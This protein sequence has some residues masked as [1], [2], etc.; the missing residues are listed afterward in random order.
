MI[1][2]EKQCCLVDQTGKPNSNKSRP[3]HLSTTLFLQQNVL[4]VWLE[5]LHWMSIFDLWMQMCSKAAWAQIFNMRTCVSRV[6]NMIDYIFSL[7]L[8]LSNGKQLSL[9]QETRPC[10]NGFPLGWCDH[11]SLLEREP[12][13]W[14]GKHIGIYMPRTNRI[15]PVLTQCSSFLLPHKKPAA[16]NNLFSLRSVNGITSCFYETLCKW[17]CFSA[18]RA[19]RMEDHRSQDRRQRRRWKY[20]LTGRQQ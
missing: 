20:I 15:Q 13:N 2:I 4:V 16:E 14:Y 5:E 12:K 17:K 9:H 19:C 6:S 7:H 18:E 8:Q 1:I 11:S 3:I 10:N